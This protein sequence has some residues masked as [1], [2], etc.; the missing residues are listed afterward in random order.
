[1]DDT[2]IRKIF[3]NAVELLNRGPLAMRLQFDV[4]ISFVSEAMQRWKQRGRQ[5]RQIR[6]WKK[7]NLPHGDRIRAVMENCDITIDDHRGDRGAP[8]L[9]DF[10]LAQGLCKKR[11][12][13]PPSPDVAAARATSQQ[14]P[15]LI[16]ERLVFLTRPGRGRTW[17]GDGRAPRGERVVAAIPHGH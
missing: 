17:P 11:Q 14:Q 4:S 3:V 12:P 1:M 9:G 16:A 13:T 7:S 6:C 8:T 10:L 5:S 15:G 2:L